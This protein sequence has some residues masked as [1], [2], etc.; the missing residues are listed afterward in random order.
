[1]IPLPMLWVRNSTARLILRLG[2]MEAGKREKGGS[3]SS[4]ITRVESALSE[5]PKS[6]ADSYTGDKSKNRSTNMMASSKTHNYHIRD[7]IYNPYKENIFQNKKYI[8][9]IYITYY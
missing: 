8:K 9:F 3:V 2:G 5:T 7:I 6:S 4:Y 1:M